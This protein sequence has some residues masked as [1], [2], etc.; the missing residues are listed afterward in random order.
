M[1]YFV[2]IMI[3]MSLLSCSDTKKES[4]G[5]LKP[6][7]S[8][9]SGSYD[10]N[11]TISITSNTERSF[12]YYSIDNTT[13]N[14]TSLV[15]ISPF[16]LPV[17]N[18]NIKAIAFKDGK[19]SAVSEVTYVITSDIVTDNLTVHFKKPASWVNSV[20][21]HYWETSPSIP[22][23]VWPGVDMTGEGN[24]WFVYTINNVKSANIIFNDTTNQTTDLNRN[25][26][27]WYYNEQW[28]DSKPNENQN[29]NPVC[30][31]N[32]TCNEINTCVCNSGYEG[33]PLTG[34]TAI[35]T[36]CNPV[37]GANAT[38]NESNTCVC[39][40]GYEGNPITGCT[41]IQ[42]T[43]NPVCGANATCNESNTC[44]C[45]SGYEG[46]PV[47]GCTPVQ[48]TCNPTCGANATC[49]SNSICVCNSGYEGN[50]LTGCTV[51][52]MGG[53][54]PY[55]TNPTLGKYITSPITID[56]KNTS[57]EWK[58]DML[59]A[60]DMAGDD[61]RTLGNNW[62]MHET[63]WDI[64]HLWAAWDNEFL[65]I[66]WQ[67]VDV[68]DIIDPSNAGSAGGTKPIQMNLIQWLA[69]DTIIN[70]GAELDM[71]GKNGGEPYWNGV[72]KPD[73]QIYVG[74]NLTQGYIS[75]A[76]DGVFPVDDGGVNY[77]KFVSSGGYNFDQQKI[78]N[79]QFLI[80]GMEI[81]ASISFGAVSLWGVR[82]CDK[83]LATPIV[84]SDVVDFIT[85]N[86]DKNRDIFYEMKIPLSK[87]GVTKEIIESTGIGIMLGQG[88][89]SCMDTIPN[90]PA[91]TDTPGTTDS[92]S[93]EEWE[94]IDLLTVP[95]ARIGHLK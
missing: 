6:I 52:V 7:I 55:S 33:N 84:E 48:T 58:D 19:Y 89:F 32:A 62:T 68:T 79:L 85:L 8:P 73:Y 14:N 69:I 86:H 66:A 71:W 65:Y 31:A 54:K 34:C 45:N 40:S 42:T 5:L 67:Y 64:S 21:L 88:E 95:F 80:P 82:D 78:T 30:G 39:N 74:S 53:N 20:K 13:P 23:S 57:N 35:Q 3:F 51:I 94:D 18:H 28:Y 41:A 25:K 1:K 63:P 90:D 75:K 9:E 26:E 56:G 2:F 50:P 4:N 60:L 72:D 12:V 81:N 83:A 44:V 38:C 24:D 10:V 43:C 46:N 92:N 47:T 29:C 93:S 76:V 91:T 49:N 87:L 77:N 17:G 11:Q 59:I 36:T 27:G 15:Y 37:C 70:Q 16:K 61:P 22:D